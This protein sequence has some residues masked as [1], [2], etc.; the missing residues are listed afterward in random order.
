M[1]ISVDHRERSLIDELQRVLEHQAIIELSVCNLEIGDITLE[2]ETDIFI[3]ERKTISDLLS[4]IKDGRYEEQCLR[5]THACSLPQHHKMYLIEGRYEALPEAQQKLVYST[6]TS[7]M[8]FK[9]FTAF[10]TD[11]VASTAKFLV[12]FAEKIGRDLKKGRVPHYMQSSDT[13]ATPAVDYTSVVKRCKKQ[14]VTS[15]NIGALMLCQIPGVSSNIANALMDGYESFGLFVRS[16]QDD[17][18]CIDGV[19]I[20]AGDKMR[21]VSKTI[22]ENVKTYFAV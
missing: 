14:N 21:K 6:I 12:N 18:T 8:F 15:E 9:G 2:Y 13:S 11:G 7:L 19:S 5:L 3:I 17:P 10:R 22:I 4:S 1:R 20:R 16:I